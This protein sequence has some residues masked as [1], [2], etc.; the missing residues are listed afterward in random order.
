M[1][2]ISTT[3]FLRAGSHVLEYA[4]IPAVV[5]GRPPLVFLHEGLGSVSLWRDFP[6]RVAAATGSRALVYS[7]YGHGRS[8]VLAA[9]RQPDYMHVEALSVLPEVLRAM[10]IERPVLVG[11]S[12]GGSIALIHAGAG[13]PCA[14]IA[15]LAPHV[16]VEAMIPPA[17][18][19]TVKHF[20]SSDLPARLA[21]HHRDA[22]ATF[23]GWADIWLS[24]AFRSWNIEDVLPGIASPILA[25]QGE[26]DEYASMVHLERIAALAAGA[27]S[28]ELLKYPGCGHSPQRDRPELVLEALCRWISS[29]VSA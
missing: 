17:I 18:A 15:V 26:D 23:F 19:A 14:G 8:D 12:D 5:P 4:D 21:R 22:R 25:I 24:E 2:L 6:Q 20:E 29:R 28:V 7:R 27:P 3:G 13:H 16:F 9:P 10:G 1:G 11:H